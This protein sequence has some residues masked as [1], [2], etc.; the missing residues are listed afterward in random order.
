MP[1]PE[2]LREPTGKQYETIR[3]F[4]DELK[5]KYVKPIAFLK[6]LLVRNCDLKKKLLFKIATKKNPRNERNK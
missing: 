1:G 2:N 6:P 4:K 5:S 3:E